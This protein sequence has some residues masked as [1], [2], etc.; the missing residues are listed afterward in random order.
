MQLSSIFICL[1][2]RNTGG[3]IG[4]SLFSPKGRSV[5]VSFFAAVHLQCRYGAGRRGEVR[6][7]SKV[8]SSTD[9]ATSRASETLSS[10]TGY[11]AG[12]K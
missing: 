2:V 3:G 5:S 10:V 12:P 11:D 8:A 6:W 7:V 9:A 1:K 4:R